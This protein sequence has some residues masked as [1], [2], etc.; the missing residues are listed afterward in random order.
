MRWTPWL[1]DLSDDLQVITQVA[2]H[3]EVGAHVLLAAPSQRPPERRVLDD[4][5]RA[6]SAVLHGR[7]EIARDAVLDLQWDPADVAADERPPLPERLGDRQAEALAGRFLDDD[8]G[9][10]LERVDLD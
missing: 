2:R 9:E 8:R 3:Q 6:R 10:R 5:E 4:L 7:D 1:E